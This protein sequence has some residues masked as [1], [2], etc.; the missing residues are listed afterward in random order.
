MLIRDI[1]QTTVVTATPLRE[2][3]GLMAAHGIRHLPVL[4]DGRLGESSPTATSS[5]PGRCHPADRGR[6]HPG[7][8]GAAAGP[9]STA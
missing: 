9:R 1:M 7:A 6:C 8:P 5:G 2:A 3:A 4:E